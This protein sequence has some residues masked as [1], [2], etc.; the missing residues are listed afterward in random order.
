[1]KDTFPVRARTEYI[2]RLRLRHNRRKVERTCEE[3]SCSGVVVVDAVMTSGHL[4][5][6]GHSYHELVDHLSVCFSIPPSSDSADIGFISC[7][8]NILTPLLAKFLIL[9]GQKKVCIRMFKADP[10]GF[11]ACLAYPNLRRDWSKTNC[12]LTKF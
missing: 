1:M 7:Y 3:V 5:L 6:P 9:I 10:Q 11:C 12:T 8:F 2:L 4:C